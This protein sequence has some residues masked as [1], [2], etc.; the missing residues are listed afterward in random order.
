[1]FHTHFRF[2]WAK[3]M[4]AWAGRIIC[5]LL[6]AVLCYAQDGQPDLTQLS[7]EQLSKLEVTS[8]SRK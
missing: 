8:V 1:M 6:S 5:A 7:L 4:R 3:H 2:N